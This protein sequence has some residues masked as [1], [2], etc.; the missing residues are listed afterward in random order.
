VDLYG[1]AGWAGFSVEGVARRAGVG[2][3]SI[4][5]RWPTKEALLDAALAASMANIPAID[6]GTVRGDLI[7]LAR[8]LLDLYLAGGGRAAMRL[9]LDGAVVPPEIRERHAALGRSQIL[10]ARG[11]VR[12]GI[13]RGE[14]PPSTSVTLL[15]DTLCGGAMMHATSTPTELRDRVVQGAATYAE[16]LVDFLLSSLL[17]SAAEG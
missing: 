2:K 4:Y 8:Q 15:L 17:T 10:A 12:R 13:R 14:L 11:I 7:E 9:G 16:K 6:T 1:D 5:L 3:A